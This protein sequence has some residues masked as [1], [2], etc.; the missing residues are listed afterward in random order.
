[1]APCVHGH[2]CRR[3]QRPGETA[4]NNQRS[5]LG[6]LDVLD[7][8]HARCSS[9]DPRQAQHYPFRASCHSPR[10]IWA[11]PAAMAPQPITTPTSYLAWLARELPPSP[12]PQRRQKHQQHITWPSPNFQR[13]RTASAHISRRV[14]IRPSHNIHRYPV[15]VLQPS[16]HRIHSRCLQVAPKHM[17]MHMRI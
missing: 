5:V 17:H 4:R 7:A 8:G 9:L 16:A 1:M 6:V 10:S 14:G 11:R 2:P 13:P 15:P 3:Q 12:S